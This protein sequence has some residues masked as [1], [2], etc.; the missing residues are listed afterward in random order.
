M[1]HRKIFWHTAFKAVP[2]F[3]FPSPDQHPYLVKNVCVCVCV[4]E[5][6]AQTVHEVLLLPNNTASETFLHESGAV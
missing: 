1:A 6:T 5:R 2:I 4:C 3:L